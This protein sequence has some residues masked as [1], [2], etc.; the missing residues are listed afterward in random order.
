[1]TERQ[2][3]ADEENG[4][5]EKHQDVGEMEVHVMSG[6]LWLQ[7]TQPPHGVNSRRRRAATWI[8]S[9]K[10][11][12]RAHHIIL[13]EWAKPQLA[14]WAKHQQRA[15]TTRWTAGSVRTTA[16]PPSEADELSDPQF[17][18][19]AVRSKTEPDARLVSDAL[20]ARRSP[21]APGRE[22]HP[23]GCG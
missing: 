16:A 2:H 7:L 6:I 10:R 12:S 22:R 8:P 1:P 11:R 5:G 13:A 9:R 14:E 18:Q 4:E 3:P 23:A 15:G 19:S 21:L 17:P 20:R